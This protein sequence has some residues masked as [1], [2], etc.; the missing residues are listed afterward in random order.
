MVERRRGRHDLN[1][2]DGGVHGRRRPC[3]RRRRRAAASPCLALYHAA[4]D[5]TRGHGVVAVLHRAAHPLG[6]RALGSIRAAEHR[7]AAAALPVRLAATDSTGVAR[8][9]L[10]LPAL[11]RRYDR[12]HHS[13]LS[14]ARRPHD[15]LMAV[16]LVIDGCFPAV[17]GRRLSAS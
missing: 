11:L 15:L 6:G 1:R 4:A 14:G 16:W 7:R 2:C 10:R 17:S 8:L 5:H 3:H 9:P 13:L 12:V